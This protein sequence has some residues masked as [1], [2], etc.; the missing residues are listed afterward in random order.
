MDFGEGGG[1]RIPLKPR[2]PAGSLGEV[3][4][5]IRII[6]HEGLRKPSP[7]L[8]Q[9]AGGDVADRGGSSVIDR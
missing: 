1:F 6:R 7:Q 9:P 8:F 5:L 3:N 2:D 4:L